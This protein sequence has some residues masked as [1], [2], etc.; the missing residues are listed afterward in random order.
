MADLQAH[1][2]EGLL[3]TEDVEGG[4][5]GSDSLG[6]VAN[7]PRGALTK[8]YYLLAHIR[9]SRII[10]ARWMSYLTYEDRVEL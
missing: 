10:L 4:P 1:G 2:H 5:H 9:R 6:R 3:P 7:T 8:L